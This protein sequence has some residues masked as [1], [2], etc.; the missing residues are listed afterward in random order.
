MATFTG[1]VSIQYEVLQADQYAV[2][3]RTVHFLPASMKV[4][5]ADRRHGQVWTLS[6]GLSAQALTLSPLGV[7]APGMLM[8]FLADQEVDVRFNA[9]SDSIFLS[10]VRMFVAGA[11]VSNL[12]ITTP[13]ANAT[14]ILLEMVG[15]SA[16]SITASLPLP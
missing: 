2:T 10:A 5:G 13:S 3:G 8:L 6:A 4:T 1:R 14:T 16:A 15:G 7:S 11:S 9:A 12:F